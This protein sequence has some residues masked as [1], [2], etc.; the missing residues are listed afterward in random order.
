MF[1]DIQVAFKKLSKNMTLPYIK[2]INKKV[3]NKFM[4]SNNSNVEEKA[5]A[6]DWQRIGDDL[7]RGIISYGRSKA[8]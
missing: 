4:H 8:K 6:E 2:V 1:T 7:R 5:I 3:I